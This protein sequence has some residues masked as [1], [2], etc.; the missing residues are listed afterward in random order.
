MNPYGTAASLPNTKLTKQP[1]HSI[2]QTKTMSQSHEQ[3][4]NVNFL[5]VNYTTIEALR[6]K[7]KKTE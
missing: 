3:T 1:I 4:E 7:K 6:K 2:T 5:K